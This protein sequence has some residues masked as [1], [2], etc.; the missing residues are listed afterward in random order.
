MVAS[1]RLIQWRNSRITLAGG[2]RQSIIEHDRNGL[3]GMGIELLIGLRGVI[4]GKAVGDEACGVD[5]GEPVPSL[6]KATGAIPAAGES[7][8]D[9]ADLATDE[10]DAATMEARAQIHIGAVS[11]PC[12]LL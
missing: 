4:K 11:L 5:L 9:V 6:G 2:G 12:L 7:R 3:F 8:R 10:L 1:S